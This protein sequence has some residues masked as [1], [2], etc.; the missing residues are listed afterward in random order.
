MDQSEKIK[1]ARQAIFHA[2]G[3]RK[4]DSEFIKRLTQYVKDVDQSESADTLK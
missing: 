4:K 3:A 2:M 1:R